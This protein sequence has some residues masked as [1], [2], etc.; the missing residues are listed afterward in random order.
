MDT[1]ATCIRLLMGG[2]CRSALLHPAGVVIH[3]AIHDSI[4]FLMCKMSGNW[5]LLIHPHAQSIF[6]WLAVNHGYPKMAF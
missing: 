4:A 1:R 6:G 3:H 5:S 2:V